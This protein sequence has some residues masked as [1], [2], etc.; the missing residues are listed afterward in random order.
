MLNRPI[1][2]LQRGDLKVPKR[3][4]LLGSSPMFKHGSLVIHLMSEE[5][6]L[7]VLGAYDGVTEGFGR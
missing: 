5:H 6:L 7:R 1:L 3:P 2:P 4:P